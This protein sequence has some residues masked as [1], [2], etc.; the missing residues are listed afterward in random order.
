MKL[1]TRI[2]LS[3]FKLCLVFIFTGLTDEGSGKVD[4]YTMT[5]DQ[6]AKS[7]EKSTTRENTLH[8]S[9]T[10][11]AGPVKVSCYLNSLSITQPEHNK[12]GLIKRVLSASLP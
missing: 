5:S 3:F 11:D 10:A 9:E 7:V 8:A 1:F 12:K 6:Y 4:Q 2:L